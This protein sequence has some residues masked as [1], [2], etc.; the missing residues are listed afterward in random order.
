MRPPVRLPV[1]LIQEFQP[2]ASFYTNILL[3]KK[4]F[5]IGEVS[6]RILPFYFYSSFFGLLL[7]F[8]II[9][10]IQHP[11]FLAT[12]LL[13][14]LAM[15]FL[16]AS[17]PPRHFALLQLCY[18][19]GGLTNVYKAVDRTLL[20]RQD[21]TDKKAGHVLIK[22]LRSI[23]STVASWLGQGLYNETGS[24]GLIIAIS[25]LSTAAAI[26]LSL[27]GIVDGHSHRVELTSPGT[28]RDFFRDSFTRPIVT[29]LVC[30]SAATFLQIY[31]GI[32]SQAIFHEMNPEIGHSRLIERAFVV[33]DAP[34]RCVSRLLVRC[35][36]R[37][38]KQP[39]A[40]KEAAAKAPPAHS[41]YIEGTVKILASIASLLF[42]RLIGRTASPSWYMAS[43]AL[44]IVFF[45]WLSSASTVYYGKC[46]YFV[47]LTCVICTEGMARS[48]IHESKNRLF[49]SC[50]VIFIESLLH[51]VIN[52]ACRMRGLG[53]TA[54]ACVYACCA[55]IALLTALLLRAVG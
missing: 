5:D 7:C 20:V 34:I 38:W 24:Y 44:S 31:L 9:G 36:G 14:Q 39:P 33:I 47:T 4:G 6:N 27:H 23:S 45:V 53:L 8:A 54:K 21:S 10:A 32:F 55:C 22:M 49:V 30:G 2:V 1:H 35:T 26:A 50:F 46:L 15:L 25:A 37:L 52:A 12:A 51:S 17:A 40:Q 3:E 18:V 16:V 41:G 11:A 48:A 29:G 42:I 28:L 13:L 19:L 43:L